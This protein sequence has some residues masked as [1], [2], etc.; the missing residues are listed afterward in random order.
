MR[1][2]VGVYDPVG[3]WWKLTLVVFSL[4]WWS[5][6][7]FRAA[8]RLACG[9]HNS[10]FIGPRKCTSGG[11]RYMRRRD[12]YTYRQTLL[13]FTQ[14]V[15]EQERHFYTSTVFVIDNHIYS[16]S[17]ST[18]YSSHSNTEWIMHVRVTTVNIKDDE[19]NERKVLLS[20]MSSIEVLFT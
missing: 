6:R 13:T 20:Q 2:V 7:T 15:S 3:V 4:L 10:I 8:W 16:Y 19:F 5:L 12:R 17:H 9:S 14:G 1:M 18:V 11:D